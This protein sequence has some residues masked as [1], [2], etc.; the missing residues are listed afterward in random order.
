MARIL[1]GG[2]FITSKVRRLIQIDSMHRR[3]AAGSGRSFSAQTTVEKRGSS[4]V[5][6][7]ASR[8]PLRTACPK[9]RATNSSMT[10]L[11][12]PA[13]RSRLICGMTARSIR[14]NSNASGISNRHW[15]IQTQFMPGWKTPR[16]F[17][18]ATAVR[19]GRSSQDY[20]V[21]ARRRWN[22]S[23]HDFAGSEKTPTNV[24]CDLGRWRLPY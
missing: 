24:H 15:R 22:V 12:K 21:T 13:N 10:P 18:R 11:P 5:R 8:P 7:P 1:P 17:A 19:P 3:P 2:K 9:A 14:G 4:L 23:A 6:P 16:C 20:A